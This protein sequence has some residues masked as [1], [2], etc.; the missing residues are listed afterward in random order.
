ME[1]ERPASEGGSNQMANRAA[2]EICKINKKVF[3]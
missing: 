2:E 1:I 3:L